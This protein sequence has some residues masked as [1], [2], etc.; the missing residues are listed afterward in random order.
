MRT[1]I[2]LAICLALWAL[3]PTA[4]AQEETPAPTPA[5]SKS[6]GHRL[7]FYLP[8]RVFDVFDL[9][10]ARLRIGPGISVGVRA[11]RVLEV[12][13]GAHATVWGGLRGPRGEPEIPW[14]IGAESRA[15]VK[16]G[17]GVDAGGPYYG[18][19]EIGCGFQL[20][21]FGLVIGLDPLEF[22]DL[23]GGFLLF[24]PAGDDL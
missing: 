4:A 23:A 8:N 12:G 24:D 2:V 21:I 14:P 18:A 3:P 17:L 11:T 22:V 15:G 7:L 5:A 6:F 20:A 19:T 9:A 13:V 1:T 16:V 10:R